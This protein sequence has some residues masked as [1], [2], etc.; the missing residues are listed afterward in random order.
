MY[1]AIVETIEVGIARAL[2]YTASSRRV[3]KRIKR[4]IAREDTV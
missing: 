3:S 4:C 1:A 2:F